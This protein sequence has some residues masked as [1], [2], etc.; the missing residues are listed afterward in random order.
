[1]HDLF[2]DLE[3]FSSV[4]IRAAGSYKYV[5]SPDFEILLLAFSLDGSPVQAIDLAQGEAIPESLRR[6]L[7]FNDAVKHAHNAAFEWYCLSKHF[8]LSE[9]QT[10]AWLPQWRCT[11]LHS[12]YCGYPGGLDA[13]GKALELPEAQRKKSTGQGLI[14]TFCVPCKPTARNG[15][16]TRTLPRHEPEKWQLFKE[17]NAQDVATEMEVER[18]LAPWPVPE[19]IQKQWETDLAVNA[20]GAALDLDLVSGALRCGARATK[21][22]TDE[23]VALTGLDN[24]NS[25]AQLR[26]WLE[27]ETGGEVDNLQKTT[28]ADLLGGELESDAARRV[29]EIRQE[30]GKAS[31]KKYNAMASAVCDDGRVRG[32]LQFYGANRTGRWGGRIV[33]PQ[34]LPRTCLPLPMQRLAREL[35]KSESL[36]A[37]RLVYGSVPDTLSQLIRTAFVPKPG[38]VF[39][40][41]DFSAIEAR[42]ISWLAGEQWRLEVFRTHGRI[43]EASASQMFGVPLEH[44][45]KGRP[46]YELRQRG[47][48]AEL[49]LGYQGGVNALTTMDTGKSL[50][51]EEMP[52]LVRQWRLANPRIR[53]LWYKVQAAAIAAVKTGEQTAVRG[54]LFT[55][56]GVPD[57]D[58]RFLTIALPSGRKLFYARPF[59]VQGEYGDNL[60][61]WGVKTGRWCKQ[62]TYGGKLVENIVQAIARD[63]LAVAIERL[64]AAGYKIVFHVHDEVLVEAAD[65]GNAEILLADV[66]TLVS[67]PMPWAPDLPLGADGWAGGFYTKD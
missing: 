19:D 57:H 34:N 58:M 29:L 8:S 42:V 26:E 30:L 37:L 24:P 25:V 23:A 43:Y 36:D 27:E 15:Q 35:V 7:L 5:R 11:M 28:V 38:H 53:D 18:R 46:E 54:L 59:I 55:Y 1:M 65:D 45:V 32:L 17:Y 67:K 14:R 61:Y 52:G 12:L 31:V 66:C 13:V 3:T 4:D 50:T 20:R 33:Q 39:I 40:D 6:L 47:K 2:I 48:V 44:I 51:E 56:E 16:R 64:D 9:E 63:C 41:A 21:A 22:L 49:A 62:E 60:R 10:V